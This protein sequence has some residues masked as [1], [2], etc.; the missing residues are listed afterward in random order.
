MVTQGTLNVDAVTLIVAPRV[1]QTHRETKKFRVVIILVLL[2]V[3]TSVSVLPFIIQ[4]FIDIS[5]NLQ[6]LDYIPFHYRERE[7]DSS[8]GTHLQIRNIAY[9]FAIFISVRLNYVLRTL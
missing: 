1:Q 7:L 4:H 9:T 6:R 2:T 8:T 5:D 3:V